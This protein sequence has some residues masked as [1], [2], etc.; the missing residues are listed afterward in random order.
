L[1]YTVWTAGFCP[2]SATF[3]IIR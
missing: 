3:C 2:V 1:N